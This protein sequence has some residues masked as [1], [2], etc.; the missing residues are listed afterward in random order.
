MDKEQLDRLGPK[1]LKAQPVPP[2][3]KVDKVQPD[4]P[5]SKEVK[6]LLARQALREV[7]DLLDQRGY[8]VRKAIPARQVRRAISALLGLLE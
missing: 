3:R 6:D 7:K 4:Q 5:D 2:D 8:K 1:V